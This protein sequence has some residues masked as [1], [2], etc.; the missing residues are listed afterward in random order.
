MR[1]KFHSQQQQRQ[2]AIES[3]LEAT[4]Y[5]PKMKISASS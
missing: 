5:N 1:K 3:I 2:E 4:K